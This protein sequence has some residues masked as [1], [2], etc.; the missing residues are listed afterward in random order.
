ME[1]PKRMLKRLCQVILVWMS[2]TFVL[3]LLIKKHDDSL[4]V[5]LQQQ[6]QK[7]KF[8]VKPSDNN[9]KHVQNSNNVKILEEAIASQKVRQKIVRKYCNVSKT[10]N[11]YLDKVTLIR[12]TEKNLGYCHVPKVASSAW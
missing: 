10:D 2:L 6:Q 5:S 1:I 11:W 12:N 7:Q 9:S 3:T 8:I 4:R